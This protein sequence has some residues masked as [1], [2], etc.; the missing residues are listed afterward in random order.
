MCDAAPTFFHASEPAA[1]LK[2]EIWV[3]NSVK[4]SIFTH[5]MRDFT[6]ILSDLEP[7]AGLKERIAALKREISVDQERF[8]IKIREPAASLKGEDVFSFVH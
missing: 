2:R 5:Q 7:A 6:P 4:C 1:S 3:D 8:A